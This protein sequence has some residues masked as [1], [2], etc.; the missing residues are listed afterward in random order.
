MTRNERRAYKKSQGICT[1]CT[2]KA[3]IGK[4]KC[5][6]CLNK[7]NKIS[8]NA[9]IKNIKNGKC[10]CGKETLEGYY[11]CESCTESHKINSRKLRKKRKENNLCTRCG[12][13]ILERTDVTKCI[14]CMESLTNFI[15]N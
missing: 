14:N 4:T 3:E 5:L 7:H 2:N 11:R 8:R 13:P 1:E 6:S 15:W 12:K 10:Q 9:R